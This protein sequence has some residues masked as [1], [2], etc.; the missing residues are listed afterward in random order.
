MAYRYLRETVTGVLGSSVNFTWSFS[1]IDNVV[2][3]LTR[4]GYDDDLGERLISIDRT[5]KFVAY[6]GRVSGSRG[7]NSSYS[8]VTLTISNISTGD[9]RGYVCHFKPSYM[10]DP[11]PVDYFFLAVEGL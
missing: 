8:Q 3:G 9:E 6:A 1:G 2:C 4:P 10:W 5:G 7:G 11:S